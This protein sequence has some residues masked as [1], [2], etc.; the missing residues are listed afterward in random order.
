MSKLWNATLT[1][2]VPLMDE[3]HHNLITR[4]ETFDSLCASG[5]THRALDELLPQLQ[6][7][8]ALHFAEEE[9]LMLQ[10]GPD[11]ADHGTHIQQHEAFVSKVQELTQARGQSGDLHVAMRIRTY[12]HDWLLYHI[13]HTDQTLAM[14]LL[15]QQVVRTGS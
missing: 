7:Y 1:T 11:Y 6:Q 8:I 2:G 5:Q 15:G 10:L 3:Q 14:Q 4:I 9:A 13:A 12:L